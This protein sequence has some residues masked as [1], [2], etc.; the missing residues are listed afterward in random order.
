[1]N[2]DPLRRTADIVDAVA[3]GPDK[4]AG[5]VLIARFAER[6]A[7]GLAMQDEAEALAVLIRG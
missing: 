4:Q 2:G 3:I 6:Y 5:I 7:L 1:M